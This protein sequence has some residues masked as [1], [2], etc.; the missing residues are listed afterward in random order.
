MLKFIVIYKN[1]INVI[2]L[3]THTHIKTVLV[4]KSLEGD[5]T[6]TLS[7]QG[8]DL[9]QLMTPMRQLLWF[10]FSFFSHL[11]IDIWAGGSMLF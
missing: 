10:S 6:E 5:E 3:K 11:Y 8:Q 9:F 2:N 7:I 1:C 4:L